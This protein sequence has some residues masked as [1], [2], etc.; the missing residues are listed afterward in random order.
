MEGDV[1]GPVEPVD[2]AR[3]APSK[4]LW[5]TRRR[6]VASGWAVGSVSHG[7]DRI[8]RALV[9]VGV[10]FTCGPCLRR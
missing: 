6:G 8:H 3:V 7:S 10:V 1:V 2:G 5:E 9:V 4:D